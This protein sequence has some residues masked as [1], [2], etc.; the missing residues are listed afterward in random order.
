MRSY[1]QGP[2]GGIC[3]PPDGGW[4]QSD[5]NRLVELNSLLGFVRRS[6]ATA[7]V[8]AVGVEPSAAVIARLTLGAAEAFYQSYARIK[9]TKP[10][11]ENIAEAVCEAVCPSA[12]Q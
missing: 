10:P 4:P 12:A 2:R 1:S 3:P 5:V 11:K 8:E 9:N 6:F 7:A